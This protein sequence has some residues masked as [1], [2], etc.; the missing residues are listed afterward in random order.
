MLDLQNQP[1]E[2]EMAQDESGEVQSRQGD[3]TDDSTV[4]I[5]TEKIEPI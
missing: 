5:P 3:A 1:P 2:E 4:E